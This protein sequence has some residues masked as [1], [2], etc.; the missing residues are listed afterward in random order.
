MIHFISI[1]YNI[2]ISAFIIMDIAKY[3]YIVYNMSEEDLRDPMSCVKTGVKSNIEDTNEE[4]DLS[5]AFLPFGPSKLVFTK[6]ASS[7]HFE[8][9]SSQYMRLYLYI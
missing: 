3:I 8:S 7:Y 5:L 9:R 6:V 2:T 1:N 4:D